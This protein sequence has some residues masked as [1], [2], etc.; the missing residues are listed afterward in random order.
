MYRIVATAKINSIL[1]ERQYLTGKNASDDHS[2]TTVQRYNTHDLTKEPKNGELWMK[3]AVK[4]IGQPK[5]YIEVEQY[6]VQTDLFSESALITPC[7]ERMISMVEAA[8]NNAALHREIVAAA[9]HH[10]NILNEP[11]VMA[12]SNAN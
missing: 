8:E 2:W 7:T 12:A 6:P 1:I 9:M 4:V 10:D 5:I 11:L 3:Q